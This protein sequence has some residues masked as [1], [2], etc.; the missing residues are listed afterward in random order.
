MGGGS[1]NLRIEAGTL[2]SS[3][4]SSRSLWQGVTIVGRRV[5]PVAG[6]GGHVVLG[7]GEAWLRGLSGIPWPWSKVFDGRGGLFRLCP[8]RVLKCCA[9]IGFSL[10]RCCDQVLVSSSPIRVL[11]DS[12]IRSAA[13]IRFS[14]QVLRLLNR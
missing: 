13:L 2:S 6:W 3:N 8:D 4:S 5:L 14:G 12:V 11:S 10:V 9:L 7:V 1:L